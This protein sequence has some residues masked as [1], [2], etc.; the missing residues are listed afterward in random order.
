MRKGATKHEAMSEPDN[1]AQGIMIL[2]VADRVPCPL[3]RAYPKSNACRFLEAQS[4]TSFSIFI[5]GSHN[6]ARI[7]R[8]C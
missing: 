7:L 6:V 2:G 3:H 4:T 8:P 5:R 1:P